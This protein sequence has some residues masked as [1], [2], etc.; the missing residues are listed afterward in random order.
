MMRPVRWFVLLVLV[1]ALPDV[2]AAAQELSMS[3]RHFDEGNLRYGRG[4]YRGAVES[5]DRAIEAGFVS[6]AVLYNLGNAYYRLDEIGQAIRYYEKAAQWM[7]ENPELR[8]NL[9][10]VRTQTTDTFSRVPVPFWLSWWR[11]MVHSFGSDA[12]F[13]IGVVF[14]LGA[15]VALSLRIRGARDAWLR[16]SMMLAATLAVVFVTTGLAAS[17]E[18]QTTRRGVILAAEVAL[19]ES[20]DGARTDFDLHEGLILDILSQ[21]AE[22]TEV[23]LPNGVKGWVR[24]DMLGVI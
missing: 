12:L 7:P 16:R 5:Y 19:L 15:A 18:E 17:V 22:W 24:T 23:K 20:P 9:A 14:Y 21:D 10:L 11:S 4:D 1:L 8:H 6:G 3:V 2:P 13:F